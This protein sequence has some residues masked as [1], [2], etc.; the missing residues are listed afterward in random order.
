MERRTASL[1]SLLGLA[2]CGLGWL[3]G[4]HHVVLAPVHRATAPWFAVQPPGKTVVLAVL[5]TVRADHLGVCGYARPT[6]PTLQQWV[7][8]GASLTC[9]A[10]APGSWTAPS[11][12][13][14]FT[15]KRPVEHKADIA[16]GDCADCFVVGPLGANPLSEELPTLAEQFQQ[17]GYQTVMVSANPV[18]SEIAG[19]ARGFDVHTS[20]PAFERFRGAELVA[21]VRHA[22]RRQTA[23]DKPLFLFV[24]LTEAHDPLE[25]VPAGHAF[26]PPRD[27]RPYSRDEDSE[28]VGLVQGTLA[29]AHRAELLAHQTDLY[30]HGIWLADRGLGRLLAELERL[31]WT[32]AG[33]RLVVVSDHGEYL[34]EHDLFDHAVE[35]YEP[36][37][38]VPLLVWDSDGS[39]PLPP[40]PISAVHTYHLTLDG[41]LPATLLPV[42]A[43]ASRS[44]WFAN[45]H[46]QG[47]GSTA[48]AAEWDGTTKWRADG[49]RTEVTDLAADP[50]EQS[51]SSPEP[52]DAARLEALHEQADALD[53]SEASNAEMVELL[54]AAGY[55]EE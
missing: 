49:A 36:Q 33:L 18:V 11:H 41:A 45:L 9:E 27:E 19:L 30:D 29:P 26:L 13:S 1:A 2:L 35:L 25:A 15:G 16:S 48:V 23:P 22:L 28:W 44:R 24:N 46:H 53:R 51:W 8:R 10:R 12:A 54:K 32:D 42:T 34:G 14:M 21:E 17:R 40:G 39:P 7:D 50:Q 38:R 31:G 47:L 5:D 52:E 20:S 55:L 4:W 3:L 37:Q 43:T 6:S